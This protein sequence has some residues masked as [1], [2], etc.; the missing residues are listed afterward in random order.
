MS[1][2]LIGILLIISSCSSNSTSKSIPPDENITIIN[3]VL[4]HQFTGPDKN[5]VKLLNDPE[6]ATI[7]GGDKETS[8]GNPTQL[9][10]YLEEMYKP[11]FTEEMYSQFIGEYALTY[12]GLAEWKGYE[13]KINQI[14]IKQNK[15]NDKNYYFTANVNYQSKGS[16]EKST[17]IKGN[18]H[19]SE[20]DKISK[21]ELLS[22]GGLSIKMK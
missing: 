22:D 12:Q 18:V 17:T 20:D 8:D 11:S 10:L 19:F 15:D 6:N 16:S 21:F 13:I 3:K 2:L 5:L 14:E 4:K 7:I 9:D 1:F